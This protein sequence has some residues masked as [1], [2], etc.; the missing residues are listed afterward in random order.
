MY[1]NIR[2]IIGCAFAV[3]LNVVITK[4]AIVNKKRKRF[5]AVFASLALIFVLGFLPIE[6]LF[7][8][9]DSAEK[10]YTYS[11]YEKKDVQI[12]IEGDNCGFLVNRKDAGTRQHLIIP[13]SE[14]GWKI[15]LGFN[16]KSRITKYFNEIIVHIYQYKNTDDYFAVVYSAYGKELSV[17][18]KYDSDF[19]P[20]IET[21]T[22]SGDPRFTYYAHIIYFN[23]QYY[24]M[25]N[26]EKIEFENEA[27]ET[28]SV[29]DYQYFID[30]FPSEINVG[31]VEDSNDAKKKAETV[32]TETYG[33]KVKKNKPY[34]VLFDS[35][36]GVWL[37]SGSLPSNMMGG[38]PCILLRRSDGQVL[39]LWHEK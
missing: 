1:Y 32:W 15:G 10:S 24:I 6:N 16:T 2:F 8:T 21:A 35:E 29:N 27:P 13:K 37:V 18:D 26:G 36:N 30:N 3:W 23:S 11:S 34:I 20:L 14:E 28:F 12:V 9:F 7:L 5:V 22:Y 19:Y 38:V 31:T 39:A 25:V 33:K 17:S 4:S